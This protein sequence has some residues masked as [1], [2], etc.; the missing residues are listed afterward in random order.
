MSLGIKVVKGM[1]DTLPEE[2][3][4]WYY[5]EGKLKSLALAYGYQ[6]IRMPILEQTELFKR[7]IGEI[8]DIVEKEMYT[9]TDKGGESLTLR[10]EG[11]AQ[12]VR[13]VL[14]NSLLR[15]QSQRL[16]YQ[17]PMFRRENPQKGR[18]RQFYQFGLEAY[19]L[20]GP[21]VDVEQILIM[22]RLWKELGLSDKIALQLNSLG[23][24]P[25]RAQYREALIQYFQGCAL[26]EDSQRRLHT[27]PMRILDSKHPMMQES[28]QK[29]P[30]LLEFLGKDSLAHF[31]TLQSML[32]SHGVAF[33]VNPRIV[34]GLDY[35]THTVYEWVTSHL[36][37]QGTVC[38]GGRYNE[39]V[40]LMGGPA[41]PAVG[42]ALGMERL[43][44]LLIDNQLIP[45]QRF[46][47]VYVVGDGEVAQAKAF[48]LAET[49]RSALPTLRVLTNCGG[50][51]FKSQFKR[52]DK[53]G[54]LFALI[55]GANE[56]ENNTVSIKALREEMPQASKNI[57]ETID[58]LRQKLSL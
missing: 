8:T 51:S 26:D 2:M 16:W 33:E 42:F 36:G 18:Y 23:T 28:I 44:M 20:P 19:G 5:V 13:L 34:R 40:S 57:E 35:Y 21:D 52:A 29:A 45:A 46:V 53:S 38:A 25:E 7:A 50:G 22:A 4:A 39:L 6:E 47:D 32:K 27:N 55:L 9:F 41:T 30:N 43:L 17:G 49:L 11:T 54:A 58:F 14:E 24:L 37:S 56:L 48:L 10:P 1:K 15:N 3:A 12:S 31:E